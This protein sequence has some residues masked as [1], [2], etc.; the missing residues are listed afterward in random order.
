MKAKLY[1]L[2]AHRASEWYLYS[3]NIDT[4]NLLYSRFHVLNFLYPRQPILC[5]SFV[6]GKWIHDN[7]CSRFDKT[8]LLLIYLFVKS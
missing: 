7:V 2:L 5:D 1:N 6:E 3:I 8:I 4:M